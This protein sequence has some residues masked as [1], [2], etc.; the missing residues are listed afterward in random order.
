[1]AP[2]RHRWSINDVIGGIRNTVMPSDCSPNHFFSCIRYL[3]FIRKPENYRYTG[4][5]QKTFPVSNT[6]NLRA[7]NLSDTAHIKPIVKFHVE[8]EDQL[9]ISAYQ[10]NKI[11]SQYNLEISTDKTKCI[12]FQAYEFLTYEEM[13]NFFSFAKCCMTKYVFQTMDNFITELIQFFDVTFDISKNGSHK[14][15]FDYDVFLLTSWFFNEAVSTTRLF[16]VDRIG[17]NEM[18]FREMRPRIRHRISNIRLTV[19][20]NLVKIQP[21]NQSKSAAELRLEPVYIRPVGEQPFRGRPGGH[22]GRG[23]SGL[24]GDRENVAPLDRCRLDCGPYQSSDIE[25]PSTSNFKNLWD[26]RALRLR[27]VIRQGQDKTWFYLN[28]YEYLDPRNMRLCAEEKYQD[29][30]CTVFALG[31]NLSLVCLFSRCSGAHGYG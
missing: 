10:L 7:M 24:A 6:C 25:S 15:S 12:A 18:V 4:F 21:G 13:R 22:G 2:V 9:Q 28:W 20:E 31:E 19:G 11:M 17:D 30:E 3:S 29:I 23:S 26:T 16:S 1:M 5:L 14:R 8:T 27:I